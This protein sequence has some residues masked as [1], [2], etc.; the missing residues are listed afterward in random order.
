M[1]QMPVRYSLGVLALGD[2]QEELKPGRTQ[3]RNSESLL[4]LDAG[5]SDLG[6]MLDIAQDVAWSREQ[7][8][9]MILQAPPRQEKESESR[10]K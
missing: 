5:P 7:V 10:G 8:S 2:T 6:S 9:D 3:G 4:G 1:P